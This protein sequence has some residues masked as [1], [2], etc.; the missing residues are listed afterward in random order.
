MSFFEFKRTT[1][2]T[3]STLTCRVYK[4]FLWSLNTF[5]KNF[6]LFLARKVIVV[7]AVVKVVVKVVVV[8]VATEV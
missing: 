3:F 8:V 6:R 5:C 1:T 2:T 4:F 7:V